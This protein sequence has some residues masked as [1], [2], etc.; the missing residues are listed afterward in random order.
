M[1]R[2]RQEQVL[3]KRGTATRQ[4]IVE[5]AARLV[6][7]QGARGTSLD[8]VMERTGTSKSQLYH[9]FDNK[10]AL[11]RAVIQWQ[12]KRIIGAQ[13]GAIPALDTFEALKRWGDMIVAS[14]ID[15]GGRGG[16]P[17]GSL[18]SELADYSEKARVLLGE[19]FDLW[20]AEIARGLDAMKV[21]GELAPAAD[22]G[23]LA[24]AAMTA[25]QGGKL[26]AQTQRSERPLRL[27][28]DMALENIAR[29]LKPKRGPRRAR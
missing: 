21:R 14:V 5:T 8:D 22:P 28:M 29:H 26:L 23:E 12:T 24:T 19:S 4:R 15:N 18:A 11:L 17:L 6:Y 1:V 16:C 25:L 9:Y 3:T 2:K 20:E 7:E 13:T 27:A 10:D